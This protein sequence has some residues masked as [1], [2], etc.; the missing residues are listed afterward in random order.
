M[1]RVL[2]AVYNQKALLILILVFVYSSL[3]VPYF[4][5]FN[6]LSN[7]M[8]Q[9]SIYGIM[10]LAM[11]FVILNGEFDL[12]IGAVMTFAGVIVSKMAPHMNIFAA[13]AITVLLGA[14]I[15][16]IVGILVGIFRLNSFIVTLCAMFVLNGIAYKMSDARPVVNLDPFLDWLGNGKTLMIPN[17]FWILVIAFVIADYTL[18]RTK[19][20]RNIYA[21]GGDQ[22]VAILTGISV[23]F[24]KVS[25]FVISAVAASVA[26]ILLTGML[27]AG[28]P[29]VGGAAALTV[30]SGVVIG[31]TSLAGGE[32]GVRQTIV[33][34]L[35]LGVLENSLNLMNVNP[36]YQTLILGLLL[37][38]AIGM[39]CYARNR[40]LAH[41][42]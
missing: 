6:N 42:L 24:Y 10:A 41:S 36:F 9:I 35:L 4:F 27:N 16:L 7:V 2:K 32:G 11:T 29:F 18:R 17:L 15:G 33:G 5:T 23:R 13:I 39:D 31:G 30:I 26:G 21:V 28:S 8:M 40:K 37:V 14:L 12:S 22:Q 19:F 3:F 1:Y 25:V 38:I 20:G 34:M